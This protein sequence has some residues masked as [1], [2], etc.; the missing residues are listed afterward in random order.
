MQSKYPTGAIINEQ[1]QTIC[2][3]LGLVPTSSLKMKKSRIVFL[4]L[5]FLGLPHFL[6]A[7][8]EEIITFGKF[9][10]KKGSRTVFLKGVVN[11]PDNGEL[12]EGAQVRIPE[13]DMGTKTD[14]TGSY[15]LIMPIG[16]YTVVVSYEGMRT[17]KQKIIIYDDG[18]LNIGLNNKAYSL[19][20]VVIESTMDDE[21]VSK[22][23]AGVNKLQIKEIR[24]LPTFMG[25]VDV[26]RSLLLLPGVSSVGEGSSGFN[27]RG[28]SID[29]NL[30]QFEGATLFNPSHVLGLFSAFNSDIVES[31]TLYKGSVPAQFGG[32]A[33]SVLE[34]NAKPGSYDKYSF[35]GGIGIVSSRF[36]AEG[37]IRKGKTSFLTGFR[38]SYSDWMLKLIQQ[39]DIQNSAASFYD[40]N[41]IL[42]HKLDLDNTLSLSYYRS[43]DF[44]RY[45][46]DFGFSYGTNTAS[47]KWKS[48]LSN[49]LSN[50]TFAVF[51]DYKSRSFVPSGVLSFNLDNGIR[52]YQ[53][54]QDLF[55]VPNN[56]SIHLGIEANIHDMK[57]DELSKR[58]SSGISPQ[59]VQK[60][61]SRDLS[62]YL[63][64]EWE[65]SNR[66]SINMGL[67]YSIYQQIGAE[68][69]YRYGEGDNR[70]VFNIVDTVQFQAGEVVKTYQGLEPRFALKLQ[71]AEQT[72]LKLSY[73]RLR[74]YI[75]LISNSTAPTPVDI[76]QVSTPYIPPQSADNFSFG[77]YQNFF[78][79]VFESSLEFYYKRIENLIDYKDFPDL[80]LNDHI[81]TDLISG[82]GRSYGVEAY[83]RRKVGRWTGW[84]SY[85]YSRSQIQIKNADP[86]LEVN[87]GEW[88]ATSYDQPHNLS[89]V[90]KRQLRKNS[91][92][93]FNFTYRT[94]RPITGL[95]STYIQSTS[96]IP[97]F[98]ERNRY[99]IP[100]YIRL[101]LS[102]VLAIPPKAGKKFNS[103][104][105][106]S[107]YNLLARRNAFSVFYQRPNR[108]VIPKAFKLSVLGSAFPS[109]TYNFNF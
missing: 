74:Q 37:P 64:D 5:F 101:D 67:R 52:Y 19:R 16:E 69:L 87:E 93:S 7:Q 91:F 104:V 58:G 60:D 26:V 96:P 89:I 109:L 9:F 86:E 108:V 97:H 42:N 99:R 80:L 11:D 59:L 3:P 75:H 27:V 77:F 70:N 14:G 29:Q 38:A 66:L 92:F 44:F 61:R 10:A 33:S 68:Q 105:S 49:Q 78:R 85:S 39:P 25:E 13:L 22:A 73:N 32:R 95:I 102:L 40:L 47:L 4:L 53:F 84:V 30:V 21:N 41:L 88:Y 54:K 28:G 98:S 43:N 50:T 12:L 17:I 45:S 83:L 6:S 71:I 24:A 15:G 51:G 56:H 48:V 57:P 79:N 65:V 34:V 90:A 107:M 94:G 55:Y 82:T 81:E 76:W 46:Q 8:A 23:I 100:D 2:L 106:V 36:V 72:S 35:K 31:F 18:I 103:N 62:F 1:I 20:E 63:N